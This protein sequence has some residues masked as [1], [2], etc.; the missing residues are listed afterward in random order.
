MP[1]IKIYLIS[2]YII[3]IRVVNIHLLDKRISS[4]RRL[5]NFFIN[6]G[7]SYIKYFFTSVG[8]SRRVIVHQ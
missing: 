3:L 6:C 1:R 4:I 8:V 2:T 7:E 5:D